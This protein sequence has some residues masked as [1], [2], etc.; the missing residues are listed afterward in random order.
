MVNALGNPV[1]I[2][3][4]DQPNLTQQDIDLLTQYYELDKPVLQRFVLW[5]WKLLHLDFGYSYTRGA[6]VSDILWPWVWQTLKLQFV[7]LAVTL[8]AAVFLGTKAATKQYSK[9]DRFLSI[10]AVMGR[11]VPVFFTGTILIIIF[12]YYIPIFPSHGATSIAPS[13]YGQLIDQLWHLALPVTTLGSVHFALYFRLTRAGMIENLREGYI[14]AA[15]A[16]GLSEK[17]VNMHALRNALIPISTYVGIWVG[18]SIAGAPVTERI[19]SWPGLGY[20]YVESLHRLD[21]N[22]VMGITVIVTLMVLM[23]N[24]VVDS[25][26]TFLDPRITVE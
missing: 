15:R 24:I 6:S 12:A 1:Q 23:L 7:T 3:L 26:Y 18:L 8:P 22:V 4:K 13:A 14:L 10:V 16:C 19:F 25:M 20:L 21:L 2:I 5:I 17:A 9:L 11:G